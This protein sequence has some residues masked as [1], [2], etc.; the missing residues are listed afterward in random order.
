MTFSYSYTDR[1]NNKTHIFNIN[2]A[3][4]IHQFLH[5]VMYLSE[6]KDYAMFK[7]NSKFYQILGEA[8]KFLTKHVTME[9]GKALINCHLGLVRSWFIYSIFNL[10]QF[11]CTKG[12]G[13]QDIEGRASSIVSGVI[14]TSE[15]DVVSPNQLNRKTHIEHE[16]IY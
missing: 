5:G 14:P 16:S 13:I 7:K 10:L 6:P 12:Q 11:Q 1:V 15:S 9:K 3:L 8:L 4:P 2:T